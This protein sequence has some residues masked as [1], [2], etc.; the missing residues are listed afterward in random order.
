M[1]LKPV[2]PH[3]FIEVI[4]IYHECE[5]MGIEKFDP[6]IIIWHHKACQVMTNCGLVGRIFLSHLHTNNG[7]FFF[8]TIKY[9]IL[10]LKMP[11]EVPKYAEMLHD[12]MASL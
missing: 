1:C 8:P 12:M 11:L 10:C 3:N 7:F 2:W 6:R 4:R 9:R 5:G